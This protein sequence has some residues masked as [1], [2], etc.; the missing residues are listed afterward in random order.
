MTLLQSKRAFAA[1]LRVSIDKQSNGVSLTEQRLAIHV[2]SKMH[3]LDVVHW[4]TETQSAAKC[5]R[6][7]F[8][9]MI[10]LLRS[11]RVEGVIIHRID[12]STRNLLDWAILGE[13]L[14][15]GADVRFVL[16]NLDLRVSSPVK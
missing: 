1:Y 14:D 6:P 2:Y 11:R 9:K 12:R 4:Y 8:R 10:T 3:G 16:D 13:L 15:S 5:G 7:V